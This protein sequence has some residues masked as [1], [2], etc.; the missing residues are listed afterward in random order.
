ME[1]Q[2]ANLRQRWDVTQVRIITLNGADIGW[3]QSFAD[4]G[5]LFLGRLFV[6]GPFRNRGIGTEFVRALIEE[7]AQSG[8][9]LTLGVVKANPHC[10]CTSVSAFA[11]LTKMIASS[12]CGVNVGMRLIVDDQGWSLNSRPLLND[13]PRDTNQPCPGCCGVQVAAANGMVRPCS[14]PSSESGYGTGA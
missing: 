7:V 2:F 13:A 5:A 1:A 11:S 12:T 8:K 9:T 4:N 6:D 3:L 14:C 10:G